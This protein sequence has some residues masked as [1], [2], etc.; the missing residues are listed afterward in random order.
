MRP[1]YLEVNVKV[2]KDW[3]K[4]SADLRSLGLYESM[5]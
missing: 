3:R 5:Q 2:K 1:V 4:S